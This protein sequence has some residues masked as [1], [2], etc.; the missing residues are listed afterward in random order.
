V[1]DVAGAAAAATGAAKATPI[2]A[3]ANPIANSGRTDTAH[4]LPYSH[5]KYRS[6]AMTLTKLPATN[7]PR[8]TEMTAKPVIASELS[9]F[10]RPWFRR[11]VGPLHNARGVKGTHCTAI[12]PSM[13]C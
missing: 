3:V 1:L 6:V 4:H 10:R 12:A 7:I 11:A 2:P 5:V 13:T 9:G 8:R